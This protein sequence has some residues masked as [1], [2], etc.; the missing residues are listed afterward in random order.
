MARQLLANKYKVVKREKELVIS[1]LNKLR[2]EVTY[3]SKL[4]ALQLDIL[5]DLKRINYHLTSVAYP[6]LEAAG[7][8]RTRLRSI[9][10]PEARTN[11]ASKLR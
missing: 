2:D 11:T 9:K 4:S 1:H 10:T 6:I 5:R 7:E 8:L 3:D